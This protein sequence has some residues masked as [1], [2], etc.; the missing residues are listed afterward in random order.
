MRLLGVNKLL[1]FILFMVIMF[2]IAGCG[3]E[4]IS[5][6]TSY[7]NSVNARSK[8][9]I[10]PLAEQ[11]VVEPFIFDPEGLR[12]P[13]SPISRADEEVSIEVAA[14]SGISPDFT[15][16]KEELESYSLDTL[17]MVGT[18][19]MN[20]LLWGLVKAS[21]GTI[22]RVQVGNYMGK[23]HG[24]IVQITEDNIELM[25]IIPGVRKGV[26]LEHEASL[27]LIE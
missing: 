16:R 12:D 10:E 20:S 4:D 1:N 19:S 7:I 6:L 23:N 22:H 24:N 2:S 14:G 3:S 21:D 11:Q 9:P 15:R 13:F 25:E 26:W 27:A 8:T 17:R 5:D 18:L